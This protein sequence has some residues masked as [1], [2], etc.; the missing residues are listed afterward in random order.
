MTLRTPLALACLALAAAPLA[1]ADAPRLPGNRY[2]VANQTQSPLTCRYRVNSPSGGAMG[3]NTWRETPAIAAGGEFTRNAETG[4][5]TVSLDCNAA[6]AGGSPFTVRP[7][8]RYNATRTDDGK[9]V[10]TRATT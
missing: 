3:S 7:G 1:A 9:V 5:E 2:A 6:D 10:V 8:T 4:G